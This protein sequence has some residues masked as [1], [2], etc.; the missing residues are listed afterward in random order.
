MR[1]YIGCG[2]KVGRSLPCPTLRHLVSEVVPTVPVYDVAKDSGFGNKVGLTTLIG[3]DQLSG[4]TRND[5]VEM[6]FGGFYE[7][8]APS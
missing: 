4:R 2:K 5:T 6:L 7:M 3:A 1:T 8:H